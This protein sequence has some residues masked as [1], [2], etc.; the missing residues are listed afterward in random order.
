M[1]VLGNIFRRLRLALLILLLDLSRRRLCLL[2]ITLRVLGRLHAPL[3]M[4]RALPRFKRS[5]LS[6][7]LNLT[8]GFPRINRSN[9]QRRSI[10]TL[11]GFL[12]SHCQPLLPLIP[13]RL[14]RYLRKTYIVRWSKEKSRL[15]HHSAKISY[16]WTPQAEMLLKLPTC[17]Q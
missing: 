8:R 11:T 9:R 16:T 7:F 13:I 12:G 1:T 4:I 6:P 17:P 14:L 15:L 5:R 3:Y 10:R 2:R